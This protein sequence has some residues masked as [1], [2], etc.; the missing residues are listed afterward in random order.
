MLP[1]PVEIKHYKEI[2]LQKYPDLDGVWCMMDDLKI[3]IQASGD[4]KMQNAYYIGWLH[5][6]FIYVIFVFEPSGTI[7]ACTLGRCAINAAHM[8]V[9]C[10]NLMKSGENALGV[11]TC[12]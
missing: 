12:W 8:R 10:P 1:A 4:R 3:S 6:H 5:H 2:I 11:V 9:H 7:F